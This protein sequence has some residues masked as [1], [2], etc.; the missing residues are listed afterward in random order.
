MHIPTFALMLLLALFLAEASPHSAR[1]GS[2]IEA[3]TQAGYKLSFILDTKNYTA[4]DSILTEDVV[5]DATDLRPS[6]PTDGFEETVA[7]F[8]RSGAGAKTFHQITN[9]LLLDQQ[10]PERAR[11]NS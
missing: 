4:L 2:P 7:A 3:L 8:R 1:S 5:L 6:T 11:V 10:S 9:V